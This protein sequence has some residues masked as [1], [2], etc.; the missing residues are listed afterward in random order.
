M[1]NFPTCKI[2]L[3]LNVLRK[4]S[5]GY[6]EVDS[7][8]L[9]IPWKDVL[10]IVPSHEDAFSTSGLLI[11]GTSN[12][13]LDA[14]AV[15]RKY[16]SIPPVN[17][18]LHKEIPMGG[19]MGGGS[20]DAAFALKMLRELF[21]PQVLDK[22]LEQMA[23]QIGS[24]CA[25]FIRGG[26]QHATG[27]GEILQPMD[28]PFKKVSIVLLNDGTHVST[29]EAYAKIRPVERELSLLTC[30]QEEMHFW[31]GNVVNDF[32]ETVFALYPQLN[33]I[34]ATLYRQGAVYASMTGSGSTMFGIFNEPVELVDLPPM[35]FQKWVEIG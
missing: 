8:M 32:E 22:E 3:G 24:D 12:F 10:E 28:L 23:A 18:H 1:I 30:L 7:T 25:F 9:E 33:A 35:E 2:N 21:Q 13:V 14:L 34:K 16:Y 11:P 15:F 31:K 17:I 26:F 6:H 5:D 20:S 27:R 19:G 4:R 29:K